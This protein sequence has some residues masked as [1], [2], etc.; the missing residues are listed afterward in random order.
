MSKSIKDL[1]FEND[2]V[3]F[4]VNTDMI[5]DDFIDGFI[6]MIMSEG[7]FC[8]HD[9]CSSFGVLNVSQLFDTD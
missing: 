4:E 3:Y 8:R 1:R 6:K 5:P 2:L 7:N 9:N